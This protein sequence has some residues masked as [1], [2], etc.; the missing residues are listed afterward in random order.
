[1]KRGKP[2]IEAEVTALTH[3]SREELSARWQKI[4]GVAPSKGIRRDLMLR[5]VA[6]NLQAKRLGGSSV[7]TRRLLRSAIST[8]ETAMRTR[9]RATDSRHKGDASDIRDNSDPVSYVTKARRRQRRSLAPGDRLLRE[10]NGKTYVVEVIEDG[11]VFEAKVCSS[12]TA[13]A[14]QITGTHWS[15][16]RFFGL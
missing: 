13:I 12:L 14:R 15:G 3:L 6:W 11:Y 10:W 5:A 8:A 2:D 16:P 1:M 7:G 9:N 4:Y